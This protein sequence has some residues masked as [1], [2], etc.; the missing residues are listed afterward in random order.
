LFKTSD[1]TKS[2]YRTGEVAK[3]LMVKPITVARHEAKGLITFERTETGRRVITKENLIEY[4]RSRK[5]LIEDT[6]RKD[7]VYA[8]VSTHKQSERGDLDRQVEKILAFMATKNPINVEIIK[9]VGSGLNDNRKN[10]NKLLVAIL[11]GEVQRV[12]VSYRDRLT[13]F[14]F[15]YVETVC[16]HAGTEIVVVSSEGKE[17]SIQEELAEDLC[18]IIHSF[19]GKLYGLRKTTKQKLDDKVEKLYVSKSSTLT[20]G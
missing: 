19:S 20:K 1:F 3:M 6:T 12:F 10:F 9:E 13:R 4:F 11:R 16:N 5:L 7:I 17:K 8:R 18:A 14:G 2:S 15:K